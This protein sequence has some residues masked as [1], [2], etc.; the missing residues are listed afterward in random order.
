M[1]L[2]AIFPRLL[3]VTCLC[4]GLNRVAEL[5]RVEYQCSCAVDHSVVWS[6]GIRRD[7]QLVDQFQ[8]EVKRVFVKCARRRRDFVAQTQLALPPSTTWLCATFYHAEN[9]TKVKEF[10]ISLPDDSIAI[11]R[12]KEMVVRA[13]LRSQLAVIKANFTG[14][15]RAITAL[16]GR[17]S[18]VDAMS[19]V[20][21]VSL[22]LSMDPFKSKLKK[23]LQKNPDFGTL[24]DMAKVISGDISIF[25]GQD[26]NSV[27]QFAKAPVTSVDAERCFSKFK[28][29]FSDKRRAFTESHLKDAL[30]RPSLSPFIFPALS[31]AGSDIVFA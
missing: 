6:K 23:V 24:Q 3:H 25:N 2:K 13:E 17:L 16:E 12:A 5:V 4:H 18:L 28:D 7:N 14:L 11:E 9:F 31:L 19:V 20:N 26:P 30:R 8:T 10:I 29:L 22:E 1:G 27:Y 21:D 15:T